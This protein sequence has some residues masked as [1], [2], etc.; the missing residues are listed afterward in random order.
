MKKRLLWLL[1]F[2]ILTGCTAGSVFKESSPEESDSEEGAVHQITYAGSYYGFS[3]TVEEAQTGTLVTLVY[4]IWATDT[5]YGF[6]V[7]GEPAKVRWVN[8]AYVIS[9][10]MPDHDV[11]VRVDSRE[12]M[13]Y[14]DP[15]EPEVEIEPYDIPDPGVILG[16]MS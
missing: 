12:T 1:A 16:S 3:E 5:D 10:I 7:D 6:Y 15:G 13:E 9:F 2:L 14:I 8:E 4:D 11:E